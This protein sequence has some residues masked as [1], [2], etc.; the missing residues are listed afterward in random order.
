MIRKYF[1]CYTACVLMW[2][3]GLLQSGENGLLFSGPWKLVAEWINQLRVFESSW[4]LDSP[5]HLTSQCFL[6]FRIAIMILWLLFWLDY[7]Y[8]VCVAGEW[9]SVTHL[10]GCSSRVGLMRCMVLYQLMGLQWCNWNFFTWQHSWRRPV[11]TY[12]TF[13]ANPHQHVCSSLFLQLW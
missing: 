8:E 4:S 10:S 2:Y 1:W 6:I 7:D 3:T 12:S 13:W 5:V 9:V 11:L